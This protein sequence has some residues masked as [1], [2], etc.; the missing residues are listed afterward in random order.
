MNVLSYFEYVL[1][2]SR[3]G[4]FGSGCPTIG[5]LRAGLVWGVLGLCILVLD[6]EVAYFYNPH[7]QH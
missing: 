3:L 1:V 5:S 4:V 7:I 2:I 6:A